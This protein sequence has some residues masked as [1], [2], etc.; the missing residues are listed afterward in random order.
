MVIGNGFDSSKRIR[1]S[2][3]FVN[4]FRNK[5]IS[6]SWFTINFVQNTYNMSRLGMV[7]SKRTIPNS[8]TRNYA[9]RIIREVFRQ[10][11]SKYPTIDF[12]V[13]IRRTVSTSN[14]IE[15]REALLDLLN[16]ASLK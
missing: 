7:I 13:R 9:K 4:A 11:Y 15:V 16:K 3:D 14:F 2:K 1:N 10:H 8:V 5:A 6:N 12:V